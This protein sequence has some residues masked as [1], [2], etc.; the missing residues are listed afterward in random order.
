MVIATVFLTILGMV[1][2]FVL[3]ERRR[4][5][6]ADRAA[7]RRVESPTTA[8][9]GTACPAETL[10]TASGQGYSAELWQVLRIETDNGTT[11]WI[12]RDSG[13]A[14]FYQ[15]KTGGSDAPLEQDKNG[16]FLPGVQESG[17]D[18]YEVADRAGNQI[19]VSRKLLE[20]RLARGGRQV[21]PVVQAD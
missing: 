4:A 5:A 20:V 15:G 13:G 18:E 10:A 8:P 17:T 21:H 16:L 6:D 11:V 2:G 7:Q 19:L 12:C 14:L 3:G 1:G 9:T